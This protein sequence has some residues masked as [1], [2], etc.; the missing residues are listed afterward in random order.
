MKSL[1]KGETILFLICLTIVII[2]GSITIAFSF[3]SDEEEITNSFCRPINY[4]ELDYYIPKNIVLTPNDEIAILGYNG[5]YWRIFQYKTY[6]RFEFSTSLPDF[7]DLSIAIGKDGAIYV[8]GWSWRGLNLTKIQPDGIIAY[9]HYLGP[10]LSYSPCKIALDQKGNIYITGSTDSPYFPTVNAMMNN[11]PNNTDAYGRTLPI[12]P[13]AFV[14]KLD[15][16]ANIIYSTFIGG[17]GDDY[18]EDMAV[19]TQ[20]AVYITGHTSSAD[21]PTTPDAFMEKKFGNKAIF[22]T[23]LDPDGSLAYGTYLGGDGEDIGY[24]IVVDDSGAVSL[25]GRT[26][27]PNFP[28]TPDAILNNRAGNVSGFIAQFNPDGNLA[29]STYIGGSG[30]DEVRYIAQDSTG[31]LYITGITDSSDFL[32]PNANES[33]GKNEDIFLTKINSDGTLS[34]STYVG[35]ED[36]PILAGIDVDPSGCVYMAGGICACEV[37]EG[38]TWAQCVC[39]DLFLAKFNEKGQLKREN[40]YDDEKVIEF[41]SLFGMSLFISMIPC[42]LTKEVELLY[43][44]MKKAI[45]SVFTIGLMFLL[46][47]LVSEIFFALNFQIEEQAWL[48]LIF[49]RFIAD[50]VNHFLIEGSFEGF[51]ESPL[52]LT[53]VIVFCCGGLKFGYYYKEKKGPLVMEPIEFSVGG[54]FIFGCFIMI[55]VALGFAIISTTSLNLLDILTETAMFLLSFFLI[56]IVIENLKYLIQ[57]SKR[58]VGSF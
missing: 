47:A 30:I 3:F 45:N 11:L 51:F 5:W 25:T 35:I 42:F 18:A 38:H 19:D 40:P 41:L 12:L 34:Y 20:G 36:S 6:G 22:M 24:G 10:V 4:Y 29:Y 49:P 27:S 54:L 28:T 8:A 37:P 14:I 57:K 7:D 13:A 9:T 33:Y 58:Q 55:V 48:Y 26:E 50:E 1:N 53:L 2:H 39:E 23:K 52:L 31:N 21:F 43:S 17:T 46:M 56:R 44:V 15:S 32:I 16:D